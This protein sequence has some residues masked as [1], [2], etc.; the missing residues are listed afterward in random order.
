MS[1]QIVRAESVGAA[2]AIL[3]EDQGA[4]FLAG[5]TLAVR[6]WNSGDTSIGRFVLCDG[7]GL[8]RIKLEAHRAEIGAAATMAK[9]LAAPELGFLH[10]VAREIGG[11]AVR[12]MATVGGNLFAPCPFG[13]FAVAL[14]ALGAEV[15]LEGSDGAEVIGI[16]AFLARRSSVQGIVRSVAFN[17]PA[18]AAFRFTKVARRRPHGASVLSIAALLPLADG[19]VRGARV[20]YG[21][22]A[23][24]AMRAR[25]VERAL[26]GRPLDGEAIAAAVAV[27]ADGSAPADDAQASAWYRR[28][29]LPVHLARLL[30][31]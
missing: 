21:A 29:V 12:A 14:V 16:E 19:R 3:A 13:D 8:D 2:A 24:T 10:G 4:R 25:E 22:M 30:Q 5:G 27:A 18:E 23:P 15:T 31:A 28:T 26:E 9:V 17:M 7:L 6:A 1:L 11:P 20:A